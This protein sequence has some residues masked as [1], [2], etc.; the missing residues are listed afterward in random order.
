MSKSQ[1][2]SSLEQYDMRTDSWTSLTEMEMPRYGLAVC[3]LNGCLY[4]AGGYNNAFGYLNCME[5]YNLRENEWRMVAP[6]HQARR[7][8]CNKTTVVYS[9]LIFT[10]YIVYLQQVP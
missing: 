6:M 10:F 3:F 1:L 9:F 2:V 7:L 4:T 8:I 5:C